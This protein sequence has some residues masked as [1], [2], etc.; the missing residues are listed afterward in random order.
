[1]VRG[2]RR[3]FPDT[4]LDCHLM[5]ER[6]EMYVEMFADAGASNFSFHI[7]VCRPMRPNGVDAHE[8]IERVHARGMTAGMAINPPTAPEGLAPFLK[9]LD[10]VLVMSVNP[11]RSGQKFLPEVLQKVTWLKERMGT[12]TRLEIDGG[13]NTQTVGAAVAAGVDM[14]VTASA[15]FGAEDRAAVIRALHSTK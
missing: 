5:V 13:I 1:M 3:H 7:E 2:L 4:L 11:G 6:P 9:H 12:N 15:L 14:L 10:L 8:L